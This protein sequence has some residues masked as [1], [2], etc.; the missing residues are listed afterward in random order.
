MTTPPR[1]RVGVG[2]ARDTGPAIPEWAEPDLLAEA[3]RDELSSLPAP[4]AARVA[5]HL[6]AAGEFLDEDPQLALSHARAARDRAS[7]LASVREAVGVAA[8]HAG[9]YAEASRE[10]RA[11]RRLSGRTDYLAV[12][13]D[14][15]RA[16][17]RPEAALRLLA[18]APREDP[19]HGE[20]LE[21]QIVEAG[22][23]RDLGEIGSAIQVL[24]DAL[25]AVRDNAGVDGA[26]LIRLR[27]AYADGLLAA[28]RE[29]QAI[30]EFTAIA[31]SDDAESTDAHQRAGQHPRVREPG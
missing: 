2:P 6:V 14:C 5:G 3:V 18:Q 16:A 8:Y 25:R 17:G 19:G 4:N 30:A 1:R 20:W 15:E 24:R 21:Q 7:R 11:Y 9:E 23:R 12:L 28:G 29:E 26:G 10:L 22:A 31:E 13:A 27:Y